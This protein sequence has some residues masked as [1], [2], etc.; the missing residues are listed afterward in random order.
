MDKP[1][2]T[3]CRLITAFFLIT[4]VFFAVTALV[5]F[6]Y[7]RDTFHAVI[8]NALLDQ[9]E[10]LQ[11]KLTGESFEYRS[12]AIKV[13][14][15]AYE[16]IDNYHVTVIRHN[17]EVLADSRSASWHQMNQMNQPEII[18]AVN[19]D[20]GIGFVVRKDPDSG[21]KAFYLARR[22][23]GNNRRAGFVRIGVSAGNAASGMLSLSVLLVLSVFF[24][25]AVCAIVA[26]RL[27]IR[28]IRRMTETADT[29]CGTVDEKWL[30]RN[31]ATYELE[32]LGRSLQRMV[33]RFN[34]NLVRE[35]EHRK[36]LETM[37][38]S[39][40]DPVFVVDGQAGIL[41]FNS[42][43]KTLF[44]T[45]ND[46]VSGRAVLEVVR[47]TQLH[48]FVEKTLSSLSP[49]EEDIVF[50]NHQDLYFKATGVSI[51]KGDGSVFGAM[52]VLNNITRI[53]K[54]ERVRTDF[55]ANV[56]HELK[57]PITAVRGFVETLLDGAVDQP[58]N[59]M[60]FLG[61]IL[62]QVNQL[63]A[64]IEDLLSLSRLEQENAGN[65][66]KQQPEQLE[67]LLRNAVQICETTA[68]EHH[69]TIEIT[70]DDIQIS[71]N[72]TLMVQALVNLLDNAVKYG[73]ADSI[74]NLYGTI[75]DNA[76]LIQVQDRG[77][78]ICE[79]HQARIFE[80]FY[81]VDKSRSREMGGS[82]LG[83]SIVKHIVQ[84][85]GGK[86]TLQ[87]S[88]GHGTLFTIELPTT[89]LN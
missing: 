56:S 74:V 76:V 59:A 63:Q 75:K 21:T 42:A 33:N 40:V 78:G 80:R 19:R 70:C 6:R 51:D 58:D 79:E 12:D 65:D 52:I 61:I 55:V 5:V 89:L 30:V 1:S 85:H 86:V 57:T 18:D 43:F 11:A 23:N 88:P 83:L 69:V 38:R 81:R 49:L 67:H 3:F 39:M 29:L 10:L 64:V 35:T 17:G 48:Q 31:E 68:K 71:V 20:D 44:N 60:R 7:S 82:G 87:S 28:P 24:S 73:K 25:S 53:R 84:I 16:L 32:A 34:E 4:A 62:K 2:A 22:I 46:T 45:G 41:R 50:H 47:N 8:R 72:R 14:V 27:C 77:P 36:L 9:T 54:L 37:F 15:E 66:I 26:V 13:L